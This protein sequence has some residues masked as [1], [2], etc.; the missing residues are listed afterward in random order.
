M[1]EGHGNLCCPRPALLALDWREMGGGKP[2]SSGGWPASGG[3]S[4]G[5][6]T[7]CHAL[8]AAWADNNFFWQRQGGWLHPPGLA[9]VPATPLYAN[10]DTEEPIGPLPSCVS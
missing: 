5:M 8:H 3:S 1:Q 6:P 9:Q 7:T 4:T 10:A 2:G